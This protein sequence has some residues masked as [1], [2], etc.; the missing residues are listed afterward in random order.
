MGT[1]DISIQVRSK[2]FNDAAVI[3][4]KQFLRSS[5][6]IGKVIFNPI[7]GNFSNLQR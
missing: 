4:G 7:F 5:T 6:S 1:S 2:N 3:L